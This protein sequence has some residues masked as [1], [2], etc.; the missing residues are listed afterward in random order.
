MLRVPAKDAAKSSFPG[1]I[2]HLRM[3]APVRPL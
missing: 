2:S 1:I 3:F